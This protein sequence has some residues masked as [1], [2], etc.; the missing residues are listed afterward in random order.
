MRF[1]LLV[2]FFFYCLGANSQEFTLLGIEEEYF[3]QAGEAQRT[4][5]TVQNQSDQPLRL[6]IRLTEVSHPDLLKT[7]FCTGPDCPQDDFLLELRTL[8]PGEIYDSVAL[9]L[10]AGTEEV[11]GT[12]KYQ[13]FD[14][15]NP[16]HIITNHIKFHVQGAFPNG[17][18]YQRP[19]LTV[20][21]FNPN[22]IVTQASL[23]YL[24]SNFKHR[25]R[26]LIL[27]ILGNQVMSFDLHEGQH[28]IKLSADQLNNGIYFYTLQLDGKNVAT[29]KMVVRK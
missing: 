23:D 1:P 21:H 27:N 13:V 2:I 18:M 7:S 10:Q 25:A 26:I 16:L 29:K 8:Q 4:K 11:Q 9:M 14:T 24:A 17:I 19:D 28:S 5:L 22:P 20:S 6:A 15:D 12:L 3:L